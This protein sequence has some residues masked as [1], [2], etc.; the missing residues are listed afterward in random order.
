VTFTEEQ[1][2]LIRALV[3]SNRTLE[4]QDIIL[5][6]IE[7]Q[8]GGVAEA[9]ANGSA[10][11]AQSFGILKEQ[12][13][14]ALAP[15]FERLVEFGLEFVDKVAAWWNAN[16]D[17]VIR[18][19][20]EFAVAVKDAWT[21]LK[22]FA[23][24][25]VQDLLGRGNLT[26]LLDL[27][28]DLRESFDAVRTSFGR[29]TSLFG[30]GETDRRVSIVGGHF[31]FLIGQVAKYGESL[32]KLL[33]TISRVL[34]AAARLAEFFKGR[35]Q[36]SLPGGDFQVPPGFVPGTVAPTGRSQPNVVVNIQGAVDPEGTARTIQRTLNSSNLRLGLAPTPGLAVAV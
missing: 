25:V 26:R 18:R 20:T 6:A 33:G 8:V 31:D 24:A 7:K 9:T 35:G 36:L 19:M 10:R 15:A 27:V 12:I 3:E 28:D 13:A 34:D 17:E 5:G 1:Q 22:N 23:T 30:D 4:A 2:N 32:D 21:E 16:G 29:L 11:I 14:T